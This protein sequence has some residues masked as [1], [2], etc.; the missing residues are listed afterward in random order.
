M[1]KKF[2]Q[3]RVK[4]GKKPPVKKNGLMDFLISTS[5]ILLIVFA[6]RSFVVEPFYIP[7]GSMMPNLLI[8]DYILVNKSSYGYSK[9]SLPFSPN[10]FSGRVWESKPQRGDVAVFRKPSQPSVDFV[11]RIIGLPGDIIQVMNGELYVNDTKVIRTMLPDYYYKTKSIMP[12]YIP[13]FEENLYG[14]KF[15]IIEQQKN[16]GL[17]DHTP[18]YEIPEG[19]YFALGDNRDNSNDSRGDVGFIPI[20]NFIGKPF[21]VVFSWDSSNFPNNILHFL[22]WDRFFHF[23]H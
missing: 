23:I 16:E 15:P 3:K 7:S 22:R 10:I 13:Q 21:M 19:Y 11:K 6:L 1:I 17:F 18:R 8:G 5:Q 20:E 14:K 9:Y 2:F 4:K 12:Y